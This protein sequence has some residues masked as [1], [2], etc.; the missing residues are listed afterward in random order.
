MPDKMSFDFPFHGICQGLNNCWHFLGFF[1]SIFF[2]GRYKLFDFLSRVVHSQKKLRQRQCYLFV[3]SLAVLSFPLQKK[4]KQTNKENDPVKL[5][6]VPCLG[7][8]VLP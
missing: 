8:K 3:Y 2:G 4:N 5:L 6:A 7:R 1:M